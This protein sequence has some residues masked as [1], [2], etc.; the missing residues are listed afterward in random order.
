MRR[1]PILA[2]LYNIS[3]SSRLSNDED[4]LCPITISYCLLQGSIILGGPPNMVTKCK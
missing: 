4:I 3:S 2:W 1:K